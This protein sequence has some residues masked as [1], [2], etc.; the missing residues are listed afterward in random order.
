MGSQRT[1][2]GA[3]I[4][5]LRGPAETMAEAI[6]YNKSNGGA[7]TEAV[8][9]WILPSRHAKIALVALGGKRRVTWQ[10]VRTYVRKF[11]IA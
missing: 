9:S 10:D 6:A 8:Q 4:E 5:L 11:R 1:T 3:L 7:V 2:G